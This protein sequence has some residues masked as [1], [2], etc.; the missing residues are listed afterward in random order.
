M[1]EAYRLIDPLTEDGEGKHS[2]D[3]RSQERRDGLDV[4]EKLPTLCRL[5]DRNPGNAHSY[6]E[7]HEHPAHTFL[8]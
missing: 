3:G 5:D 8:S 2:S 6:Q 7:Q 4:V 1:G